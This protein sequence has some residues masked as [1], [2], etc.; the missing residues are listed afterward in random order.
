MRLLGLLVLATSL[1]AHAATGTI[2]RLSS[3]SASNQ[4]NSPAISG[5]D[6]VWT[7]ATLGSPSNFDI[8]L[9]DILTGSAVNLTNTP[10]DQE[11]LEDIDGSTVVWTHTSQGVSGDIVAYDLATARVSTVASSTS[12][13]H[14]QQPAV[15][16]RW[17][18][19]LRVSPT[20]VD[21][22]L[23]DHATGT[24]IGLVTNDAAPQGRPRV[25][26]DFVV[27]EDYGSGNADVFGWPIGGG[28]A[29]PIAT[30]PDPQVTPDLDGNTVVY[31]QTVAGTDQLF[32]F[33]L[34]TRQ[35][36]QLTSTASTKLLPRISGNRV[37]WSD[38][39]NGNLDLYL[40]DLAT[41]REEP[42]VTGTGDQFLSDIDGERVVYTDNASSYEQIYLYTFT[43]APP[44]GPAPPEGCDPAKTDAVGAPTAMA[45][46][47]ARP[48]YAWGTYTSDPK[49]T[50]WVCVENGKPDGSQ[51][52]TQLVFSVD[53]QVVLTPSDFR[54][55]ANPPRYVAAKL[56]TTRTMR[57]RMFGEGVNHLWAAALFGMKLPNSVTI[58]IRV[59]K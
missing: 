40:Y 50:Y 7:N 19:F 37:V 38:D 45:R 18:T 30:G 49:R 32:A 48:S 58:S 22:Y 42:L 36:R 1:D 52:T 33:D 54:P 8:F 47:T 57:S 4:Q 27:Y 12:N 34:T 31:V 26:S 9:Y 11:F 17:I 21:V 43:A 13:V 20:Q 44:P 46:I 28:G 6:V 41:N 29:F 14:F 10:L 35:S 23:Y 15:R 5:T 3:G 2:T 56:P 24:P 55:T 59:S 51:R 39:R 25:G 16:G 53:N